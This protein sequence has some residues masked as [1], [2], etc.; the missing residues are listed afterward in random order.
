MDN[1]W[2]I[3]QHCGMT[4]LWGHVRGKRKPGMESPVQAGGYQPLWQ[5]RVAMGS[6]DAG[7]NKIVKSVSHAS[8]KAAIVVPYPYRKNRHRW[9][10][11]DPKAGGRSIVKELGK[12]ARNLG[13]RCLRNE[14]AEE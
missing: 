11:R 13:I 9:M 12:M 4:E 14:A 1:R 10:R 6:R 8:R 5:I 7:R 3:H 2:R